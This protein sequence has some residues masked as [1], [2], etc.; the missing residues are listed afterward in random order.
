SRTLLLEDGRGGSSVPNRLRMMLAAL[1]IMVPGLVGSGAHAQ[2]QPIV[3]PGGTSRAITVEGNQRI[4]PETVISYLGLH[5]GDPFSPDR[6]DAGLKALFATG[7][8][9]DVTIRREDDTL[10]VHVVENPIINRVAF[11]GNR[12]LKDEDLSAE[13]QSNPRIVYTRTRV[14]NDVTRILDLYRR[15]GRFAATVEPKVIQLPQNRVDLVFEIDE[16]KLTGIQAIDFIGNKA[17]SDGDLREQIVT[18]E[19]AWWR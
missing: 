4:E 10:I 17:F 11:E 7:L 14:Q 16:G 8:F 6:V 2:D 15:S 3:N 13:L 9:A 12:H 1:V 19:S 18:T 5:V